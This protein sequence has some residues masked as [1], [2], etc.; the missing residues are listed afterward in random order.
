M[1]TMHPESIDHL[2]I[3]PAEKT[4]FSCLEKLPDHYHIFHNVT[5]TEK[6][7]RECDIIIFSPKKGFI[8]VE[9]KGGDIN[10]DE[11]GWYSKSVSG[12][13]YDI[14][15]PV[16]Q[17]RDAMYFIRDI[18]NDKFG[19]FKGTWAWGV[20]FPDVEWTSSKHTTELDNSNVLDNSS[21]DNVTAWTEN[22]FRSK[23]WNDSR[24][25]I[26]KKDA[27]NFINMI[28][29]SIEVPLSMKR[30]I[31]QQENG[32]AQ[33]NMVQEYII[34]L[35]EDKS[36]I[37]FHG[38]AGTGKTWLLMKKAR[39]LA[40]SDQKVLFLCYNRPVSEFIR[41][42]L[43]DECRISVFTFHALALE[44]ISR[45]IASEVKSKKLDNEFFDFMLHLFA[46]KGMDVGELQNAISEKKVSLSEKL[47]NV[48][49][50]CRKNDMGLADGK[51]L[52]AFQNKMSGPVITVCAILFDKGGDKSFFSERIPLALLEIFEHSGVEL[53]DYQFDAV[54]VDEGQDFHDNWCDCL[55]HYLKK[56]VG[57][58]F[59]A[60]YDDNQKIF[61][62]E[63]D[64]PIKRLISSSGLEDH[65]F[66][67][68]D[69]LRNT[70]NI[71]KFATESTGRGLTSRG[72]GVDGVD[73]VVRDFVDEKKAVGFVDGV[74]DELM[75]VHRI[76]SERIVVLSN[77]VFDQSIF[78]GSQKIGKRKFVFGA[79]DV[80]DG[81]VL[82]RTIHSFKGLE[83]DVVVLVVHRREVDLKA[84][85]EELL[86]V[87]FTRAKHLLYVVEVGG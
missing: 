15:Y 43:K 18:Y 50:H 38:A 83:A 73:P 17:A 7:D 37:G 63:L 32:L 31:H 56:S 12:N 35:F 34:N 51:M 30:I 39:Q 79:E 14:K 71:H 80:G 67:L 4:V 44:I 52:Q 62:S 24:P 46:K 27:D 42:H 86:Y 10:R 78:Q 3:S 16:K 57:K 82:F 2:N 1:A 11:M 58:V 13:V 25:P 45:F 36:R 77:R 85:D 19:Q 66:R 49:Y 64:L 33:I 41:D 75:V 26:D 76:K 8:T 6:T 54:L 40:S 61:T 65:I 48:I 53:V 72:M 55:E 22:V 84:L 81:C 5:W 23:G 29:R 59:Y 87:G 70:L 68:R 20:A 74:V 28:N 9:V 60:A 69:N 47:S 21:M